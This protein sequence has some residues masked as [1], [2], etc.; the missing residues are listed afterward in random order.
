MCLLTHSL[1]SVGLSTVIRGQTADRVVGHKVSICS[2]CGTESSPQSLS[3]DEWGSRRTAHH[4]PEA[5]ATLPSEDMT[6]A[7][8][9]GGTRTASPA[10]TA[11]TVS[12][13]KGEGGAAPA[14]G[15]MRCPGCDSSPA[16]ITSD[17]YPRLVLPSVGGWWWGG[18]SGTQWLPP[19]VPLR[20][21]VQLCTNMG[22]LS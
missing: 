6:P 11:R 20:I 8:S 2:Q 10:S 4:R 16:G 22:T 19:L 7:W 18:D 3:V 14:A 21:F 17:G 15:L 1:F 5:G 12:R 9:S 13:D